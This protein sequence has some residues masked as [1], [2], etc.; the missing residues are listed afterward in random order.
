LNGYDDDD[1]DAIAAAAAYLPVLVTIISFVCLLNS[2]QSDLSSSVACRG[3]C[4]PDIV[5]L[6]LWWRWSAAS[7]LIVK[8]TAGH[9]QQN[10]QQ[11]YN[12]I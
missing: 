2:A 7:L 4:K 10:A 6:W 11:F 3:L 1:D 8:L 5:G 9:E 12:T